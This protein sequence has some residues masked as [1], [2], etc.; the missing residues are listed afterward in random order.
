MALKR[1]SIVQ[2]YASIIPLGNQYPEKM[3]DK[4]ED[5][6]YTFNAASTQLDVP[7]SQPTVAAIE[8]ENIY[9][10]VHAP[11][12]VEDA[13]VAS[14]VRTVF[15]SRGMRAYFLVPAS[16]YI[17]PIG[18]A[19]DLVDITTD[20][21]DLFLNAAYGSTDISL[22]SGSRLTDN[23]SVST[24][25][26][27]VVDAFDNMVM[28]ISQAGGN[29]K[30]P[31]ALYTRNSRYKVLWCYERD[32]LLLQLPFNVLSGYASFMYGANEITNV[33]TE[34]SAAYSTEIFDAMQKAAKK[35]SRFPIADKTSHEQMQLLTKVYSA[36]KDVY[37]PGSFIM[38]NVGVY[39]EE[40]QGKTTSASNAGA[41]RE[42]ITFTGDTTFCANP[43]YSDWFEALGILEDVYTMTP[44]ELRDAF[45]EIAIVAQY[46]TDVYAPL[47]NF[48]LSTYAKGMYNFHTLGEYIDF[49]IESNDGLGIMIYE[50]EKDYYINNLVKALPQ[51]ASCESDAAPT[52][53]S[54]QIVG[55]LSTSALTIAMPYSRLFGP[56]EMSND[57]FKS[58]E[59]L[60]AGA[61]MIVTASVSDT[62]RQVFAF[63]KVT[64]SSFYTSM[65]VAFNAGGS[66]S[67]TFPTARNTATV[68]QMPNNQAL[69]NIL[70]PTFLGD[71][72]VQ[73]M[74][75]SMICDMVISQFDLKYLVQSVKAVATITDCDS[76]HSG[77][78]NDEYYMEMDVSMLATAN[79]SYYV[80]VMDKV[81]WMTR[82][83]QRN[84]GPKQGGEPA[85]KV[86]D[87]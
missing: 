2:N 57:V 60:S 79:S 56:F 11:V 28:K 46:I 14:C 33:D 82:Q 13:E 78:Y 26:A 10:D 69:Y 34:N 66:G 48:M 35:I 74:I 62:Q 77:L 3:T 42:D 45:E 44:D 31:Y 73:R 53:I 36:N 71:G 37:Y 55:S 12:V 43:K 20:T 47:I 68:T 21:G 32:L 51:V 83:G 85:S 75:K 17:A 52:V 41:R 19:S 65:L 40:A 9:H 27:A 54:P 25:F 4:P 7:N 16:T 50:V 1:L 70:S 81:E 24:Q 59:L 76:I 15:T 30:L 38:F 22:R 86:T 6:T 67:I 61:W 39:N 64:G 23:S 49:S 18:A 8:A 58:G 87:Q 29:N 63:D 72:N 80:K 5:L 84:S